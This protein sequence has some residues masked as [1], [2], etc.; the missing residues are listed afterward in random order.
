M[1]EFYFKYIPET[2]TYGAVQY[3]GDEPE[4]KVPEIQWG[5]P[6]TMLFDGLFSG[7]KEITSVIL[8]D[9]ICFMGG[10]LFDGCTNL[11]HIQLPAKLENLW[12][13]TFVRCGIEEI[14]LPENVK[15]IPPYAFKDCKNLKKLVCNDSL[16]EICTHAFDGCDNLSEIINKPKI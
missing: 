10:F 5:K 4:I 8:P 16:D 9:N 3:T 2:D 13:Y 6:V 12:Q 1:Q 11:R 7:H 15:F 14:V